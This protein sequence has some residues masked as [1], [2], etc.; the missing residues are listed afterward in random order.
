MLV[1]LGISNIF[2]IFG[3]KP[4]IKDLNVTAALALMSIILVQAASIRQ[5]KVGGW[6]KGFTKPSKVI[7]PLNVMG[8]L[9]GRFRCA[10]VFLVMS[11][12]PL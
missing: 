7:T 3:M 2:A 10:C 6:L 5:N 12:A 11:W 9:S 4:P 1:F 8:W